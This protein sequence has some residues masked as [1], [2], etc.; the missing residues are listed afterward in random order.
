MSDRIY[1]RYEQR[2]GGSRVGRSA[3]NAEEASAEYQL[4]KGFEL[5]TVFGDAGVGGIY[6]FWTTKR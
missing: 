6:L 5:S 2:Y 1:V 3:T 4:G